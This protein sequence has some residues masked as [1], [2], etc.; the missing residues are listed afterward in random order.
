[1]FKKNLV[2]SLVLFIALVVISGYGSASQPLMLTISAGSSASPWYIMAAKLGDYFEREVPDSITNV[3]AGGSVGNPILVE[4]GT[5]DVAVTGTNDFFAAFKGNVPF[6]NPIDLLAIAND[7][8][9]CPFQFLVLKNTGLTSIEQMIEEKYPIKIVTFSKGGSPEI[10]ARRLLQEYGITWEDIE[11]WGGKVNFLSWA[12]C[13]SYIRDGHANAIVGT[14]GYPHATFTEIAS[15]ADVN[16]LPPKAE[17]IDNMIEKYG[18]KNITIPKG[19]YNGLTSEAIPSFGWSGVWFTSP[20]TSDD[21]AYTMAK[22]FYEN[23]EEIKELHQ[24]F[25]AVDKNKLADDLFG[26]I[27]PG[28]EKF[29]KE[30]G[31]IK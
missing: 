3:M 22:I 7:E 9:L 2:F 18:Y 21:I 4:D 5:V 30:V 10:A 11:S 13:G 17:A 8:A 20:G 26:R 27:H 1:M 29:Y 23:S 28:A 12:D 14:T 15:F 6:D 24:T 16:L 19:A 31:L 25:M